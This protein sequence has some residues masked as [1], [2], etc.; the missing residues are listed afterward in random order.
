MERKRHS[1]ALIARSYM[2]LKEQGMTEAA[3]GV[4]SENPSG[5]RHLY[6]KM[7]FRVEKRVTFFRK[8]L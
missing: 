1:A 3:L 6:E 7:G 2:V 8:P 5:A 4:D